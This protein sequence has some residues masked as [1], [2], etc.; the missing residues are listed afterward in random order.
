MSDMKKPRINKW[1]LTTVILV[2]ALITVSFITLY[3]VTGGVSAQPNFLNVSISPDTATL[4]VN[5]SKTFTAS[6]N[7][8]YS[9]N[10]E[11]TWSISPSDNKTLL[12][13]MGSTCN[14]TFIE[15][16]PDRYIISCQVK[17]NVVGNL[18]S[19][20]AT[21][22]DPYTSPTR[23]L[24]SASGLP[25]SYM[26]ET[27]GLGW[28][29]AIRGSDGAIMD[30]WSST[31]AE[32]T[33]NAALAAGTSVT[34]MDGYYPCA[35]SIIMKAN[36]NLLG[37]SWGVLLKEVSID[38][39]LIIASG[40]NITVSNMVLSQI[41]T[42]S[43]GNILNI[44]GGIHPTVKNIEFENAIGPS[45][46]NLIF[47]DG[48]NPDFQSLTV[49]T[50]ANGVL[51]NSTNP[52]YNYGNGH[53]LG[54]WTYI[55]PSGANYHNVAL[56]IAGASTNLENLLQISDFD[57]FAY[58]YSHYTGM[59]LYN[60]Q[61]SYF[62]MIDIEN[63]ETGMN[64]TYSYDNSF[65]KCF[66]WNVT[67]PLIY[68]SVDTLSR[69]IFQSATFSQSGAVPTLYPSFN[70]WTISQAGNNY[71]A[72]A[73]NG[74]ISYVSSDFATIWN[75]VL[76]SMGNG[77]VLNLG[78][79]TFTLGTTKQLVDNGKS[80]ITV[81]GQGP[82]TII[83]LAVGYGNYAPIVISNGL[84][85]WTFEKF[86]LD[87]TNQADSGSDG[88]FLGSDNSTVKNV[89]V[90]GASHG[91]IVTGGNF[92]QVLNN[93]SHN[94]RDD[95]IIV[96]KSNYTVVTG[97]TCDAPL[98]KNGISIVDSIGVIVSNN[99]ITNSVASYGIAI[100]NLYG[101]IC[102]NI[103]ITNN[104]ILNADRSGIIIYD[105]INN[106]GISG[107]NLT[108]SD[109]IIS[110]S[111][112][113]TG[114]TVGIWSQSGSQLTITDNTITNSYVG[115]QTDAN[116]TYAEIQG[117]SITGLSYNTPDGILINKASY[118]NVKDNEIWNTNY[119]IY[120]YIAVGQNQMM[121]NTVQGYYGSG[122][123][124]FYVRNC[125][126]LTVT[127]NTGISA[128]GA[129][130]GIY[131]LDSKSSLFSLNNMSSNYTYGIIEAST[132]N[133][134]SFAYNKYGSSLTIIG[135]N[136]TSAGNIA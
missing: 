102:T 126:G 77:Q 11:Y 24:N 103:I 101:T 19:G 23:Y 3:Q 43:T 47:T 68:D 27:D 49:D 110:F 114:N 87:C 56:E 65:Q 51:I 132:S 2:I 111:T 119:G 45:A 20:S 136:S 54:L 59:K 135:A 131:I 106:M 1:Q 16:T 74:T 53:I 18:G 120:F 127:E 31:N 42:L 82:S 129:Q 107:A 123:R 15:A 50:A 36:N 95:A 62:S 88:I 60:T 17:D 14:L 100:E 33:I 26:I 90:I 121:S 7:N 105:N 61:V 69:N 9:T 6:I 134:N 92:D 112:S 118:I 96:Y 104:E 91:N 117:N 94:A 48:F 55:E 124:A 34:I 83:N 93:Y 37:N 71:N 32:T 122:S 97:N 21:V 133:Y 46:W 76:L 64:L 25:Y 44:Q 113:D 78:S 12:L 57:V 13:P 98:R 79:G 125:T 63:I 70:S 72:Q 109:N 5:A 89:E 10:L 73:P 99:I 80:G 22:Y 86:K 81:I 29:R 67:T 58:S 35:G 30:D 85:G 41:G 38:T 116:V 108:I 84:T 66:F 8:S 115:I 28:Y 128:S 4:G 130:T 52:I 39:D 75:N 40:D